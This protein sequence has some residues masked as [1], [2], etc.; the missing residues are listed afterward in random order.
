MPDPGSNETFTHR[1]F[2]IGDVNPV[3]LTY[4]SKYPSVAKASA[5]GRAK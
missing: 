5:T 2:L 3:R 4:G 1:Y